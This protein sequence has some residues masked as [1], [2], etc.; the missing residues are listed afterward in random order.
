MRG[1]VGVFL[2][3]TDRKRHEQQLVDNDRRK[4]EFL[5]ML[6]HEL[7]NPLAP[8][9]HA[10]SM[11]QRLP[12]DAHDRRRRALELIARQVDH[13]RRLV[14]DLLDVSRITQGKVRLERARRSTSAARSRPASSCRAR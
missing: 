10:V 12:E 7:R 5:A 9:G 4:D 2:D 13:L 3:I 6:A 14:D 11:L 1:C 8:I